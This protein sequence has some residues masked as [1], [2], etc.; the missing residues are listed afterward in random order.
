MAYSPITSWHIEGE[1]VGGVTDFI[2]LGSKITMDRDCSHEMK[3]CLLLG[4]K[5]SRS[6][7]VT[8]FSWLFAT[9]W[10]AARQASLSLT[11]SRSLPKF[12]SVASVMPSSHL[13][14]PLTP[15]SPSALKLSQHQGL[16]QLVGCLYLVTKIL[17]LQY[18]SFQWAFSVDFP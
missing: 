4:R 1:K 14:P 15:S 9:Q 6:C 8:Q 11:I 16:F 5:A 3:R 13:S 2:F 7:S 12:M 10:T 17:E 18:Q